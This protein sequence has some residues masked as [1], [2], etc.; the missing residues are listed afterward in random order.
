[1]SGSFKDCRV[2]GNNPL[3]K[4]RCIRDIPIWIWVD[5]LYGNQGLPLTNFFNLIYAVAEVLKT[6]VG[7]FGL[8]M[9]AP[10]TAVVSGFVLIGKGH[11]ETEPSSA[12]ALS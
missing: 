7:S 2:E 4:S 12:P 8:V 1:M 6:L 9:V 5:G 10:F 3:S 11:A